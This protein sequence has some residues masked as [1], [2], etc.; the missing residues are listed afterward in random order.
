MSHCSLGGLPGRGSAGCVA[1]L[2]PW[3]RVE[4]L[5]LTHGRHSSIEAAP[6]GRRHRALYPGRFP[7]GLDISPRKTPRNQYLGLVE[8]RPGNVTKHVLGFNYYD[9]AD[10]GDNEDMY[11]I[12]VTT[13]EVN[14]HAR[15]LRAR[16]P[17]VRRAHT[18]EEGLPPK[19]AV[20]RLTEPAGANLHARLRSSV[21][22]IAHC[23]TDGP[24]ADTSTSGRTPR[25]SAAGC[26]GVRSRRLAGVRGRPRR[27][28]RRGP[29]HLDH[30]Y[31]RRR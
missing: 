23:S 15:Q 10:D 14:R 2:D 5:I 1:S 22:S 28:R 12:D 18:S 31:R 21:L 24:G 4:T 13:G 19:E 17:R 8:T 11:T 3:R 6:R 26:E 7:G 16:A 9:A 25:I 29:A 30:R 27:R 20:E